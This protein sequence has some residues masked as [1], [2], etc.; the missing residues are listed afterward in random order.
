MTRRLFAFAALL[1]A[2]A[3]AQAADVTITVKNVEVGKGKVSVGICDTGLGGEHCPVGGQQ[4]STAET[5]EFIF[6]NIQADN[7]ACGAH[8]D[9][10]E[11]G[12]RDENF[13]GIP[14]EPVALSNGA[15]E[16]MIPNFA[17]AQ[18]PIAEGAENRVEIE[19]QMYGGGK[20]AKS[21]SNQR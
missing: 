10:N 17:D 5:L 4:E 19:L 18:V 9:V 3:S 11:N 14:K 12:E 20:K 7:Y 13:L 16:K 2:T 21:A 8:Q 6:K 1:A 15:L